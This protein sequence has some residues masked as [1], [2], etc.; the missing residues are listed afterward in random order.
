MKKLLHRYD[1]TIV[2]IFCIT[3]NHS[4]Y[5]KQCL[6][7]F[8]MQQCDFEYEILIHDDASTDETIEII[9][10]YCE[11]YPS[12]IKPIIQQENQYS[13]GVRGINFVYNFPRAQGKYIAMCEGDDYWTDPNKLQKQVDLLEKNP[14]LSLVCSNFKIK[15]SENQILESELEY[16]KDFRFKSS[17]LYKQWIA[18]TLTLMFRK[19]HIN[20]EIIKTYK[21]FRDVHLVNHLLLKGQ[22]YFLY[23]PTGVYRIHES[24]VH[25]NTN[26]MQRYNQAYLTFS[27]IFEREKSDYAANQ[28]VKS[29][30]RLIKYKFIQKSFSEALFVLR[31]LLSDLLPTSYSK[32]LI[33][34]K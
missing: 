18:K 25:S 22:G 4:K 20:F 28:Y 6:D 33:T 13:K 29:A 12:L 11:K 32:F 23:Q 19:E 17:D 30:Y 10:D 2:S 8:L 15:N 7:G 26:F 24:G 14:D 31:K 1:M 16:S 9:Q 5:I 21:H 3:Y 27:E 34:Y